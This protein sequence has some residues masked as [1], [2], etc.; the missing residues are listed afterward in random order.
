[1]SCIL[2]DLSIEPL[3]AN[4]QS[5]NIQGINV[6]NLNENAIVSMFADN[7]M[8]ILTEHDSL[9]NLIGILDK[10]CEVSGAKF[11]I[12]K[13]EIIPIGSEDYHKKLIEMRE[14]G[15]AGESIPPSIHIAKDGTAT[16]ILGAWVGNNVNQEEPWR[17]ITETIGKNFKQWEARYLTLEGKRLIV[18]MIAG[19]K[20][21]FLTR[22]Q[23][24]P[25]SIQ[26]TIHKM[27]TE[28]VWGKGRANMDIKD[29]AQAPTR[30]G[31]KILNIIK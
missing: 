3:A 28:F 6:P 26:T 9:S 4:I 13:T 31:R 29:M 10:W 8:V 20:T 30:G 17:K 21:Q 22:A 18:Q 11:N 19:R 15:E 2:F 7:T 12:Q 25:K 24:M 1:M 5:S 16:R 14:I 27:I 23:G